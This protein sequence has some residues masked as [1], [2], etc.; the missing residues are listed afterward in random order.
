MVV[1]GWYSPAAVAGLRCMHFGGGRNVSCRQQGTA[2]CIYANIIESLPRTGAG[3]AHGRAYSTYSHQHAEQ[4][5][6]SSGQTCLFKQA[7]LMFVD[8]RTR[9][10]WCALTPGRSN[11]PTPRHIC[12]R[13]VWRSD[14]MYEQ[15]HFVR[16][17]G[18]LGQVQ[19]DMQALLVEH[20]IDVSP[21]S[22][23]QVISQQLLR[24]QPDAT[25]VTA[26]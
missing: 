19:T 20:D 23:K 6:H 11:A 17:L 13:C 5:P 8:V 14:V 7:P 3:G 15:G 25:V 24:N 10:L 9:E 1:G 21:F 4:R 22:E 16:E 12:R 26:Q 2:D 18:P